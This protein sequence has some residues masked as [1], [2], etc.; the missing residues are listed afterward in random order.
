MSKWTSLLYTL[1]AFSTTQHVVC[2]AG[3]YVM[4]MQLLDTVLCDSFCLRSQI[5]HQ[6]LKNLARRK[7]LI[8][9]RA[10][11]TWMMILSWRTY[12]PMMVANCLNQLQSP[13]DNSGPRCF[14]LGLYTLSLSGSKN[15][16]SDNA[17][18]QLLKVVQQILFC[19]GTFVKQR[20]D[21]ELLIVLATNIP[22]T[23]YSARKLL[24]VNRDWFEQF[25][26]CPKCTKLY[27]MHEIVIN[28]GPRT[29]ARMCNHIAFPRSKRPR[30]CGAQLAKKIFLKDGR[31]TFYALKTYYFKS[32]IGSLESLLKRP[33][34]EGDCEKWRRRAISEELYA[35][36]YDGKHLERL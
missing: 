26:V 20:L 13:V 7:R 28:D 21:M 3:L 35:D 33:G 25:F 30:V 29:T 14:W 5:L 34:L 32:I 4:Y 23:L 22:T 19:V 8:K 12:Y 18:E 16:I 17:I 31:A 9:M 1:A 11:I 2:I 27:S 15:Y 10:Q 24:N 6:T 36:V